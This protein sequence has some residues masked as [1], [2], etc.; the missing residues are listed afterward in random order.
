[1]TQSI[2]RAKDPWTGSVKNTV[3]CNVG[4]WEGNS[5]YHEYTLVEPAQGGEISAFNGTGATGY[6]Y[7]AR[8]SCAH[9]N[10][11]TISWAETIARGDDWIA[12]QCM[13]ASNM[14]LIMAP[15]CTALAL[16]HVGIY[17]PADWD[18]L[19]KAVRDGDLPE[20]WAAPPANGVTGNTYP[21]P[22]P[23]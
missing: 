2:N 6:I 8:F 15:G 20:P 23:K 12:A 1:M 9:Q 18:L 3:N 4:L 22:V 17:T 19:N 5:R 10:M 14:R 13:Q 7:Y 16:H 21:F 11:V